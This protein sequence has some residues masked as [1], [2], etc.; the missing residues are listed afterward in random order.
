MSTSY[1]TTDAPLATKDIYTS[2]VMSAKEMAFR[3]AKAK[4]DT[5]DL[6]LM[7]AYEKSNAECM[8]IGHEKGGVAKQHNALKD[9]AKKLTAKEVKQ[10]R[11]TAQVALPV[12]LDGHMSEIRD[13]MTAGSITTE[14]VSEFYE[15]VK[16]LNDSVD[17]SRQQT[18]TN[19]K[20][21]AEEKKLDDLVTEQRK[22]QAHRDRIMATLQK[23][24]EQRD[25]NRPL[26]ST[27]DSMYA[28][29]T[30]A[31]RPAAVSAV[32]TAGGKKKRFER[33]DTGP[34]S[35]VR[36]WIMDRLCDARSPGVLDE[37]ER[38]EIIAEN[39]RLDGPW[40]DFWAAVKKS[41]WTQPEFI[42]GKRKVKKLAVK[43]REELVVSASSTPSTRAGMAGVDEES[44]D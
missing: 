42:R 27:L 10:A 5:E 24:Q 15:R 39:E 12:L 37:A 33:Q 38:D 29:G 23:R 41:G 31:K 22:K 19:L 28:T 20:L 26:T 2:V 13:A 3:T 7:T 17:I 14:N 11:Y 36:E 9:I 6:K 1:A 44:D 30:A 32:S 4:G 16:S 25:T 34:T 18:E 8:A 40:D 21:E 43:S 35:W